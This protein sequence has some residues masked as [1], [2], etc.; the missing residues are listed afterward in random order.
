M[1]HIDNFPLYSQSKKKRLAQFVE[2]GFDPFLIFDSE[3]FDSSEH[4]NIDNNMFV[5]NL[6]Q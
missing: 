1:A 4:Q 6:F 3:H 5:I 2:G